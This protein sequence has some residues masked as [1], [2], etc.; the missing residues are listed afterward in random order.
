MKSLKRWNTLIFDINC[1]SLFFRGNVVLLLSEMLLWLQL[2]F[3]ILGGT[4]VLLSSETTSWSYFQLLDII[5]RSVYLNEN[6]VYCRIRVF[7]C[8]RMKLLALLK[9]HS[10]GISYVCFTGDNLIAAAC[11]D[12]KISLWDVYKN[13]W[14]QKGQPVEQSIE[15]VL[16]S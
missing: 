6:F 12:G 7:G 5:T 3:I 4:V 10:Q 2:F 14:F 11:N 1:S 16:W 15:S 8:K 13:A 9:F